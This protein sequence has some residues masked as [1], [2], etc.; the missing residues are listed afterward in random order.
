MTTAQ[1]RTVGL[2]LAAAVIFASGIWLTR[3]G[4]PY[5]VVLMTVHKLVDLA[6]VI[7]IGVMVYQ[8]HLAAP[9]STL[10]WAASGLA[11][12]LTIATF[13]TGGVVSAS[14]GAPGWVLWVH[15]VGSWFAGVVAFASVYLVG[16]R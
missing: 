8:A 10:E 4:R 5:G 6:A 9:L 3:T 16:R 11:A 15:R 2:L 1:L 14:E 12:L 13:S 7:V